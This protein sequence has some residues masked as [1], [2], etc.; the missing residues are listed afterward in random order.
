MILEETEAETAAFGA[1][2]NAVEE[3]RKQTDVL[4]ADIGR[5]L[6]SLRAGDDVR[7]TSE[8]QATLSLEDIMKIMG[9]LLKARDMLLVVLDYIEPE[10]RVVSSKIFFNILYYEE[11]AP[12]VPCYTHYRTF[13]KHWDVV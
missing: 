9:D 7:R 3:A 11:D 2:W 13:R 10:D 6:T 8:T 1:A 5:H 4:A 12:N